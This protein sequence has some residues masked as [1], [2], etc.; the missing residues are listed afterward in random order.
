LLQGRDTSPTGI[1][2]AFRGKKTDLEIRH[3]SKVFILGRA[4]RK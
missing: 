2:P 3:F 4:P 1:I